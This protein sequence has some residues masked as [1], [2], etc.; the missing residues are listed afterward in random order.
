MKKE[1]IKTISIISLAIVVIGVI[2]VFAYN[3]IYADGYATGYTRGGAYVLDF[4]TSSLNNGIPRIMLWGKNNTILQL[5][6][7]Q[8]ISYA[9]QVGER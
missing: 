9:N 3:S 8:Y 4:Q 5:N 2:G 7:E 1:T 6:P